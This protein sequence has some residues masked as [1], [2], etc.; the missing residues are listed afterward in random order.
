MG[1]SELEFVGERKVGSKERVVPAN[2]EPNRDAIEPRLSAE[3]HEVV[4]CEILGAVEGSGGRIGASK[5]ERGGVG[6]DGAEAGRSK[7]GKVQRTEPAHRDAAD[8]DPLRVG[9]RSRKRCWD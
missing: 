6:S 2:V 7:P 9:L 5:P 3:P 4:Q 1:A 8:R